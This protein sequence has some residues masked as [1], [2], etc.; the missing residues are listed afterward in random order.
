MMNLFNKKSSKS[1]SSTLKSNKSRVYFSFFSGCTLSSSSS[2]AVPSSTCST[3][4][5]PRTREQIRM[6]AELNGDVTPL[7]YLKLHK[8]KDV[9]LLPP[10]LPT[11]PLVNFLEREKIKQ[12][13]IKI[14][15]Q[16]VVVPSLD[17][18]LTFRAP[19]TREEIIEEARRNGDITY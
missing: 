10:Q 4:S 12:S 15:N 13:E 5:S 7:A 19:R 11:R 14:I 9:K 1:T 17:D 8:A 3:S 2:S 18:L 16:A 6:E